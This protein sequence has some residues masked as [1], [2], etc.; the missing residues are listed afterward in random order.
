MKR[1]VFIMRKDSF[2]GPMLLRR[3]GGSYFKREQAVSTI[4][5]EIDFPFDFLIQLG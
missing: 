2:Y 1:P 5:L 3:W 4:K